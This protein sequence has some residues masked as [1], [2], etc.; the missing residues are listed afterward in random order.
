MLHDARTVFLTVTGSA[1][2]V[3]GDQNFFSSTPQPDTN[4]VHVKVTD[5][6]IANSGQDSAKIR[7]GGKKGGFDQRRVANGVADLLTLI[8]IL[9]TFKRYCDELGGP[10][11]VANNR[12]CQFD[13]NSDYRFA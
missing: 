6:G 2:A 7:I 13:G 5:T 3:F 4:P 10:F 1:A 11:T 8:A 9:A 12:L